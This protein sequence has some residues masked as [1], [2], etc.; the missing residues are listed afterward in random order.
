MVAVAGR[1]NQPSIIMPR[2]SLRQELLNQVELACQSAQQLQLQLLIADVLDDPLSDPMSTLESLCN[3]PSPTSSVSSISSSEPTSSS[4]STTASALVDNLF[5]FWYQNLEA[6][7]EEIQLTRVLQH[8][9]PVPH[10]PQIQLLDEHRVHRLHLFRK[11]VRV[12]PFTFDKLVKQIKDHS[13]FHNNSNCLNSLLQ[14]SLQSSSIVLAIMVIVQV[15]IILQ[16]GLESLQEQLRIIQ[17]V[18]WLQSC[19]FT[20]KYL[21]HHQMWMWSDQRCMSSLLHVLNGGVGYS[22]EMGHCFHCLNDQAYMEMHGLIGS[23]I[24]Q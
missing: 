15:L 5:D 8:L 4:A 1:V 11:A 9:P 6:T 18:L 20:M 16:I 2:S 13:V 10:A 21:G 3:S 23:Q 7:A 17:I 14:P 22:Q 19:S 12:N 24:T